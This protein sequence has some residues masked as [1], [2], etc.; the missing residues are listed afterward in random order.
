MRVISEGPS[1]EILVKSIFF[2][3]AGLRN[4][5]QRLNSLGR[6]IA[7]TSVS[8]TLNNCTQM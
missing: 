5:D 8:T 6:K 4:V 3:G 2:R 7:V 1:N